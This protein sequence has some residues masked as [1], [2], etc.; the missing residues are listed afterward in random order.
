MFAP[1]QKPH[2]PSPGP[3]GG[4]KA[5]LPLA[6]SREDGLAGRISSA[7]ALTVQVRAYFGGSS[8][9]GVNSKIFD[10]PKAVSREIFLERREKYLSALGECNAAI[11]AWLSLMLVVKEGASDHF[12]ACLVLNELYDKRCKLLGDLHDPEAP[13][14]VGDL[15]VIR[16]LR[17]SQRAL[18]YIE[19]AASCKEKPQL[20]ELEQGSLS[21][22]LA[23]AHESLGQNY[24]NQVV[25]RGER[26][27]NAQIGKYSQL[28]KFHI[29]CGFEILEQM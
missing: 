24:F 21:G 25:S 28:Q 22:R 1:F 3:S 23:Q 20:P 10:G 12:Q 18:S 27:T 4:G 8:C 13:D 2:F 19:K 9:N 29:Q 15:W 17:S 14:V 16:R 11:A 7:M 5:P 6:E 26:L